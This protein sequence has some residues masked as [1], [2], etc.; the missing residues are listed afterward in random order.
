MFRRIDNNMNDTV[1]R[2]SKT[3][4]QSRNFPSLSKSSVKPLLKK[5]N[6]MDTFN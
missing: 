4:K 5:S 1:S 3:S 6:S 2:V